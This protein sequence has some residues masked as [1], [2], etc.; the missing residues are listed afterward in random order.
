[1][2]KLIHKILSIRTAGIVVSI[3]Y[4][5]G[6]IKSLQCRIHALFIEKY[7]IRETT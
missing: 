2:V 5:L 6:V 4:N 1:M 7:K 3:K